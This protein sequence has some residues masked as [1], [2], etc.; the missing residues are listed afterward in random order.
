MPDVPVTA[1]TAAAKDV[2]IQLRPIGNVESFA[3]IPV[4]AQIAGELVAIHFKEGQD[5]QKGD[6]LFEIDR[7][8][9]EQALPSGESDALNSA[10][11]REITVLDDVLGRNRRGRDDL[12]QDHCGERCEMRASRRRGSHRVATI[13]ESS[14]CA[15]CL[16]HMVPRI[17]S[18]RARCRARSFM[19]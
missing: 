11:A 4:K 14:T 5:V 10:A 16:K 18:Q 15:A 9:Y 19:R 3:S 1:A 6:L 12:K 17:E 8:P 13:P 7:R 2:P